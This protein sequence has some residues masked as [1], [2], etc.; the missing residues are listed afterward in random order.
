MLCPSRG[1]P[2]NIARLREHWDT[3]TVDAKL[4]VAVDDDDPELAGYLDHESWAELR[5]LSEPRGLGPIINQ[6]AMDYAGQYEHIGFLGDDHMPRTPNWDVLLTSALGGLPGVAYGDDLF[7]SEK[8]PTSAVLSSKL[9]LGLGYMVPPGVEHLYHDC[10]WKVLGQ[11][12]L[13]AWCPGVI[14]EHM[15][16][17]ASKAPWDARYAYANSIDMYSRDE[18]AYEQF[19]AGRWP[20]DRERL[21]EYLA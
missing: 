17:S 2:Q 10:F 20:R 6:L 13:L 8:V 21:L 19:L 15:H 3:V 9:I 16:P 7:Q 14:M 18:A 12:T 4:L 5:V 1:R 11:A